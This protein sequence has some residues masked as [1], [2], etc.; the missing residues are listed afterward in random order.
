LALQAESSNTHSHDKDGKT[1]NATKG[2][3]QDPNNHEQTPSHQCVM[4]VVEPKQQEN[5][6]EVKARDTS[7]NT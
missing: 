1:R 5:P 7:K 6:G 3:H 4:N 2:N